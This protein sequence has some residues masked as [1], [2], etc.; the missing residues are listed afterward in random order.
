L[1]PNANG[2]L[3]PSSNREF[4]NP[5]LNTFLDR[6]WAFG[7]GERPSNW[8]FSGSIQ[9]E[10]RQGVSASVAYF[11]R[12][13]TNF[14]VQDNRAVGP[15]DVD[16]FSVVA[17]LDA[18]L[19]GGGGQKID[20]VPDLKPS[21]VGLIDNNTLRS[22]NFGK[23]TQHWD[24]ID[25]TIDARLRGILL[26]G[27]FSSGK[28]SVDEC[29][30]TRALPEVLFLANSQRVPT[31]YCRNTSVSDT[32]VVALV[33]STTPFQTQVKLLGS[34][35]LPYAVQVAA[36]LQSFPGPER[37]AEY[38]Y[39]NAEVQASLGRPLSA[40]TVVR[41]NLIPP[42]TVFGDRINQLDLRFSKSFGFGATRLKAMFDL[43]NTLNTNAAT[44]YNFAFDANWE[45]PAIIMPAR[46]AKLAFQ[47]DF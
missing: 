37:R 45:R 22:D 21:V 10:L 41:V 38:V 42:G 17:P 46:M 26:Q 18:R 16:Y 30:L 24:G 43:Y 44:W 23:R 33:G 40:T 5:R 31:S 27:G 1:N 29:D 12:V 6:N 36:T 25:V 47:W 32:G 28:T 14:E 35:T 15:N 9:R 19:P 13:Y 8:E 11:R 34:Y 39:S 2:E 4:G 7:F 20:G 3:G